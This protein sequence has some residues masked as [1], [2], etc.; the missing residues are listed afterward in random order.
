MKILRVGDPHVKISNINESQKLIDFICEL[1]NEHAID[2][3]EFLGDQFHTHAVIRMEVLDFWNKALK[4]LSIYYK[5]IFML[6]GNHDQPG[7]KEKEQIMNS[8]NIFKD[9]D[10]VTV[11]D[12]PFSSNGIAYIPYMSNKENFINAS[13]DLYT[14]GSTKL[15]I[16]HQTF[17]GATYSNGFYAEDGIEPELV[18]QDNIISGHIH[19]CQDIGKC[20]YPGTPKWDDASDANQNK[21]VWLF[22]HH[23]NG[24]VKSREFIS[25][26]KVLTS[27]KKYIINEGEE[28]PELSETDQNY[29]EFHGKSAWIKK[30][31]DKYKGIASI[32]AKPTDRKM[33][34]ISILENYS[35]Y[36]FLD[37]FFK[38]IEGI[39]ILQIKE[40]MRE[41]ND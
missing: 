39:D 22:E 41:I 13:A 32:K 21:G 28:V 1:K 33:N 27:I 8:I 26:E 18:P 10:S 40:Y 9:E 35:L 31:K 11:I 19:K 12:K 20:F 7:S 24:S 23:E 15:L 3:I 4:K 37:K 17:T 5:E 16:A 36:D 38:P 30:M 34:K 6:V 25:T 2:R 14:K 29:L